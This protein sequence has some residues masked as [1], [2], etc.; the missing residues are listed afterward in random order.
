MKKLLALLLITVI[1][2]LSVTSC[3]IAELNI[4]PVYTESK[5]QATEPVENKGSENLSLPQE[6]SACAHEGG[7]V[8][9][10][11]TRP[12]CIKCGLEYGELSPQNHTKDIVWQKSQTSHRTVYECC[13]AVVRKEEAHTFNGTTC[14]VCGYSKYWGTQ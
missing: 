3:E 1:L 12:I 5:V 10:C 13:G 6:T 4:D 7:G 2:T 11:N 9:T 14:S 8:A